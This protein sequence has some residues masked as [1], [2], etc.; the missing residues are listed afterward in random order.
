VLFGSDKP[1]ALSGSTTLDTSVPK[2]P[3]PSPGPAPTPPSTTKPEPVATTAPAA[4]AAPVEPPI[5]TRPGSQLLAL[6]KK[7]DAPATKASDPASFAALLNTRGPGW[8]AADGTISIPLPDGKA[9]WLFGDTLVN[10]PQPDGSLKLNA[11]FVRNSAI[12]HDGANATTLLT[13]TNKDAGDFLKPADP[14]EW[15]WPGSG[16]VEGDELIVFMG[17]V[18]KT[19]EGSPGWNFEGVG[20]D[21]VRLDLHDLSVKGR[22]P[23]PE[24]APG[25][26]TD[27]GSAVVEDAGHTYVYGFRGNPDDPYQRESVVAR[28]ATDHLK[29]GA[30]EYWDGAAWSTDPAKAAPVATGLSNSYSV[31]RTPNGRFAMVSQEVFFGTKLNVRT[32]DSPEGPWS[33]WHTVDEGPTK[34]PNQISYNAQVHP[35][36]TADG[37]MLASWNINTDN[38]RLPG[39]DELDGY[40]PVFRAID[41][42]AIEA[43]R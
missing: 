41:V 13:G 43:E 4:P 3:S 15:Y 6:T 18:R 35:T 38:G 20:S 1:E 22:T 7:I 12:L 14:N 28:T 33:D 42:D 8:A 39:P 25:T 2:V 11:D 37:K 24:G 5:A 30:F 34:G 36:F 26:K 17:R 23:M 21:M 31:T 29:D 9:L 10:L 40:R 16:I 32:A 19:A 27:W